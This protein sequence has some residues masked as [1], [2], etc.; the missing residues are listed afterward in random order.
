MTAK[1]RAEA[2][3]IATAQFVERTQ[4]IMLIAQPALVFRDHGRAVAVRANPERVAP[5]AATA[6][7]DG[8][9][10]DAGVVFIENSAHALPPIP[11]CQAGSK[12]ASPS[13]GPQ[14]AKA[15]TQSRTAASICDLFTFR[16]RRPKAMFSNTVKYG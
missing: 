7:V 2:D 15:R 6:D 12:P 1:R 3:E 4:K 14:L 9:R 16:A 10:G 11:G 13:P 5:L 8:A